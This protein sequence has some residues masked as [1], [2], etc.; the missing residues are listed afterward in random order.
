MVDEIR[1]AARTEDDTALV[2]AIAVVHK[3]LLTYRFPLLS[4]IE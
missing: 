1:I 4:F 3:E 2:V